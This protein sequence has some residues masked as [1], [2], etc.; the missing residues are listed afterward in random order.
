MSTIEPVPAAE[1]AAV[2]A[3]LEDPS[4]LG[5]A[6]RPM[7][8]LATGRVV[9]YEALSRFPGGP[10]DARFARAR[11]CGLGP[12]LEALA[13]RRALTLGPAPA[14]A[15]VS[16]NVSPSA[17]I[18]DV[19]LAALPAEL[20]GVVVEVTEHEAISEHGQVVAVLDELRAR[21][22]RVALDDAGVGYAGLRQVM[23]LRP[24]IIKLDRSL[25]TDMD[26]DPAK[27]ALVD[28]FTR[29]A[30][31]VDSVVCAEGIETEAELEV[32]GDL[33]VS[34]G[35]GYR[36]ARPGTAWPAPGEDVARRLRR[37][38][39]RPHRGP[40]STAG[41]R[42][43]TGDRRLEQVCARL[44]RLESAAELTAA[45]RPI[46][47]ELAADELAL[48][49][50]DPHRRAVW[51]VHA[52]EGWPDESG[53]PAYE[54]AGLPATEHVLLAQETVQVLVTDP[55]ADPAEVALLRADGFAALLMVPVIARGRTLGLL[56]AV[57]FDEQAFSRSQV[58]R[59][60]IVAYQ[61]G[62][63]LDAGRLGSPDRDDA[64]VA[65]FATPPGSPPAAAV[66]E[67]DPAWARPT[68]APPAAPT[69]RPTC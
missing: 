27:A 7:V 49:T 18:S 14:A 68:T 60:R 15:F 20:H 2:A 37:R 57:R 31:R 45:C 10:P 65:G 67:S 1:R 9:G 17:L 36:L 39:A 61:L 58:N 33:D 50:W 40:S 13:V 25:I 53:F 47:E 3:L 59:A 11:G 23:A 6:V 51:T 48:S 19:L 16:V 69:T 21:G 8:D 30:R 66:P 4:S 26:A 29:F 28:A 22:A 63:L 46:A 56:E 43:D 38:S 55:A 52:T 32:L 24:D 64:F 44:S 12:E 62:A 54:L 5:L 35:Q 42:A 34:Y 41:G